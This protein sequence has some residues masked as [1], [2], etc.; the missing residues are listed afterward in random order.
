MSAPFE[1]CTLSVPSLM[2]TMAR[3][4]SHLIS[5]AQSSPDGT[6]WPAVARMGMIEL[7]MSGTAPACLVGGPPGATA[8]ASGGSRVGTLAR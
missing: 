2:N 4:P 8:G 1:L 6:G 5:K 7:G 3:M